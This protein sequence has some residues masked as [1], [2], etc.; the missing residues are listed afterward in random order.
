MPR[1]YRGIFVAIAGLILW[2]QSPRAQGIASPT[3]TPK[4]Q[5]NQRARNDWD[6]P[7]PVRVEVVESAG[8]AIA[9]EAREAKSDHHD[10]EDLKAQIRAAQAAEDQVFPAWLAAILSFIGSL[11]IVWTLVET[12]RANR[13]SRETMFRQLRAYVTVEGA[14]KTWDHLGGEDDGYQVVRI[15]LHN[16]GA[17]PA[18]N[19]TIS[20]LRTEVHDGQLCQVTKS[21]NLPDIGGQAKQIINLAWYCWRDIFHATSDAPKFISGEITYS[22]SLPN[23]VGLTE[24]ISIPFSIDPVDAKIESPARVEVVGLPSKNFF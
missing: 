10:A 11:L 21:R 13:I 2:S 12:R 8:Q 20:H 4:E 1:G 22:P 24:K 16:S 3:P 17:T 7:A 14:E 9:N 19:M 5:A 6:Q 23:E 18:I 15:T